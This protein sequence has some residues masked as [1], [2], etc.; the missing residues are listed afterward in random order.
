MSESTFKKRLVEMQK[1]LKAP[2]NLY[3]SFGKYKYRNAEGILEAAKPLLE[4][5]VF[6]SLWQMT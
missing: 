3:N 2:K 4:N 6:C 1:E 5:I